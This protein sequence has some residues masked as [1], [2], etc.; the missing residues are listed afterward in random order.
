MTTQ[1]FKTVLAGILAGVALFMIPFFLIRILIFFLL[2]KAIFRLLGGR[3]RYWGRYPAYAYSCRTM[4][5]DD[6]KAFATKY[7]SSCYGKNEG[8]PESEKTNH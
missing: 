2:V 7:G 5:E 8:S 3:R 4:S 1:I 6:R